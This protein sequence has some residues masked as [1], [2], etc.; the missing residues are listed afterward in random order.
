MGELNRGIH[1]LASKAV[2]K[3]Y[4]SGIVMKNKS[5]R[6]QMIHEIDT[7]SQHMFGFIVLRGL[8]EGEQQLELKHKNYSLSLCSSEN[9]NPLQTFGLHLSQ[10]HF[11][12]KQSVLKTIASKRGAGVSRRPNSA[13]LQTSTCG[14]SIQAWT[15]HR[16]TEQAA[17]I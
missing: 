8:E 10:R 9:R 15:L 7:R 5:C 1:L 4:F 16:A 3:L 6:K 14:A 13:H 17:K 11:R 2:V 12:S